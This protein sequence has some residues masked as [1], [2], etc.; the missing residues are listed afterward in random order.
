VLGLCKTIVA[1]DGA[2]EPVE[3]LNIGADPD[4]G[5]P[6]VVTIG[7]ENVLTGTGELIE[8]DGRQWTRVSMAGGQ[9]GWASAAHLEAE[10]CT[11]SV[12]AGIPSSA[13]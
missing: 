4:L 13:Q 3:R 7:F 1:A 12:P 6:I 9:S 11:N 5:A 10:Q 8:V 2:E